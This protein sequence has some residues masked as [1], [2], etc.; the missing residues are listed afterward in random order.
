MRALILFSLIAVFGS[1][2]AAKKHDDFD[3]DRHRQYADDCFREEHIR[4]IN[5]YYKPRS[6]PAGLQKKLYRTGTLPPG[7]ERKIRPFPEPVEGRLPPPCDG[8]VRGYMDGYAVVYQPRTRVII[9]I[10]AVFGR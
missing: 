10:H 2:A 3:R 5:E 9:D 7:W 4:V 6:L 8:C 1:L